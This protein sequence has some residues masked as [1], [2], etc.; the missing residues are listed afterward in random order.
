MRVPVCAIC[1]LE[2]DCDLVRFAPLQKEGKFEKQVVQASP[3][4][5]NTEKNHG[6]G[7]PP[8]AEWFCKEHTKIATRYQHLTLVEA[9]SKIKA[10]IAARQSSQTHHDPTP[11]AEKT[12]LQ[13]APPP[14]QAVQRT[15]GVRIKG[16]LFG[17]EN[18][19]FV[20][21]ESDL[22]NLYE[23]KV[24]DRIEC[25]LIAVE[26]APRYEYCSCEGELVEDGPDSGP[27]LLEIQDSQ[28]S[29]GGSG[30]Q[31]PSSTAEAAGIVDHQ[32]PFAHATFPS[33][34]CWWDIANYWNELHIPPSVARRYALRAGD[35]IECEWLAIERS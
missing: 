9:W 3:A 28:S 27:M 23:L 14:P 1:N 24:G 32:S 11:P 31:L 25:V 18:D 26:R 21:L 29:V 19:L 33:Q 22:R 2:G 15:L 4:G 20:Y 8:D 7:P 35:N 30:L 10:E 12:G 17:E 5:S 13:P 34:K 16:P 6:I